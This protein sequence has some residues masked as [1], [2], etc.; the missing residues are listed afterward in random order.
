ML[1]AGGMKR[2]AAHGLKLVDAKGLSWW[3]LAEVSPP[4][5]VAR[6]AAELNE[7]VAFVRTS[8]WL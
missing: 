7:Y 2:A 8:M 4:R 5:L 1:S 6:Y 3:K